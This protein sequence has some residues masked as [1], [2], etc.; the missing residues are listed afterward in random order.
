MTEM[1]P[2]TT[3]E[4]GARPHVQL[5]HKQILL[6]YS[7]LMLGMLLSA[8]D[9]TIVSTALPTIAGDLGGFSE[10]TWVVTAYL[11]TSTITMLMWGKLSDIFGRKGMF[12]A[13][14]G[15]FLAASALAGLAPNMMF[16]VVARGL[17]GVGAG[18]I[19]SLVFAIIGDI[20]SPRERGKYQ[21]LIGAVFAF[22]TVVGPLLGGSIVDAGGAQHQL[23]GISS[24]RWIFYI[25]LPLGI[26]AIFITGIVLRLPFHKQ[27]QS[28]DY[29]GFALQALG[30]G[31][32]VLS[33]MWGGQAAPWNDAYNLRWFPGAGAASSV[34]G[35]AAPAGV[36]TLLSEYLVPTLLAGGVVLFGLFLWWQSRAKA[37]LLPLRLFKVRS[38]NL[39][40]FASFVIGAGMFGGIAF[41]PIYLQIST[42]LSATMSGLL[43]LPMM[44]GIILMSTL[45][46]IV[47]TKTGRYRLWPVV[48]LPLAAVGT[49]ILSQLT[50]DTP[51]LVLSVGMFLLGAGIG[52]TMQVMVLVVQNSVQMRDLG[53]GTATNNYSRQMG[54]VLGVGV[55]GALFAHRIA[56]L[57]QQI[58]PTAVKLGYNPGRLA[59]QLFTTPAEIYNL[60]PALLGP[61]KAGV[62]EAVAN[63]FLLAVP[64]M[65]VGLVAILFL[66]EV[67]LRATR[68]VGAAAM[69]GGEAMV[70]GGGD[71]PI[72][73]SVAAT[74]GVQPGAMA[75]VSGVPRRNGG[76]GLDAL[77]SAAPVVAGVRPHAAPTSNGASMRALR[78]EEI[79]R[80]VDRVIRRR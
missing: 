21:G 25:N 42:G 5:T 7:G 20:L 69:E 8:L 49:A 28:I 23:L 33:M 37:P 52:M 34:P 64:V 4:P 55:L 39:A 40:N 19:M 74:R 29:A 54:A 36:D 3:P 9:Q 32:M 67:P 2:P 58:A 13:A 30:A 57:I 68:N 56:D 16:L 53:V 26:P 50:A 80:G 62:A 79:H 17:Q 75:N 18:G 15:I 11:L 12:Q 73:P 27:K 76:N 70:P 44:F 43:L 22:S 63:I 1:A 72:V 10:F 38:I 61:I 14:I 47:I 45:S 6:V 59:R 66:K 77:G 46:G 60:P 65:V 31:A 71:A 51:A 48:G 24:W 78:M 41:L 35:G